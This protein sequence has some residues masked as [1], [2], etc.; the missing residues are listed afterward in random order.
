MGITLNHLHVIS[1]KCKLKYL[2]F[3]PQAESYIEG[4]K[5]ASRE[6]TH[7]VHRRIAELYAEGNQVSVI[8]KHVKL[9]QRLVAGTLFYLR[10]RHGTIVIKWKKYCKTT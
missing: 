2:T 4:W 8:A 9:S 10:K 1:H 6:I 7:P 3:E 5:R